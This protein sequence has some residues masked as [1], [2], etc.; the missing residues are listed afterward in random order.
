[1][2]DDIL[3]NKLTQLRRELH[4]NPELSGKEIETSKRIK[5]FAEKYSPHKI[6]SNLGGNGV[7]ILFSGNKN[8]KTVL[9][10]CDLDALP[11]DE[12]NSFDHKSIR[13][14]VSHKCGHD[15]HMAIVCGLIP[16]LSE[17]KIGNG[18]V[19]LLFQPSEETGQGD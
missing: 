7:A 11:I 10:R 18:K 16:L 2:K 15:G 13:K 3:I 5:N 8:G 1:M 14:N 9:I 6:I 4:K 12:A 19:V 17:N